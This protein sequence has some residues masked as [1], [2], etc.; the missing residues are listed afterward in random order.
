MKLF[1]AIP[2]P[3]VLTQLLVRLDPQLPGVRWLRP[4]QMHLTLSFLG[5]VRSDAETALREKLAGIRFQSFFLPVCGVGVFPGKGKPTV[6]WVGVGSG[7]PQLFHVY[8]RVQE[9][10]LGAGLEPDLRSWRPHITIARCRD[11]PAEAVRPFLKTNA[12]F[13]AGLVPVKSFALYSSAASAAG[14]VYTEEL[15]VRA[16]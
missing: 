3:P 10:A 9:A 4:E 15:V 6:F 12:K 5:H 11:V 16:A 13:D 8:K 2:L 14:S 7:H 1:V